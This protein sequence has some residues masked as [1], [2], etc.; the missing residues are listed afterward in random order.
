MLEHSSGI[1]RVTIKGESVLIPGAFSKKEE[2]AF[3]WDWVPAY[4]CSPAHHWVLNTKSRW[5]GGYKVCIEFSLIE[6]AFAVSWQGI[7]SKKEVGI[8]RATLISDGDLYSCG[9]S[10]WLCWMI[11]ATLTSLPG[12]AEGWSSNSLNRKR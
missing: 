3:Q 12:L 4:F 5:G 8:V 2:I 9:N 7:S 1:Y 10:W 6:M 11:P